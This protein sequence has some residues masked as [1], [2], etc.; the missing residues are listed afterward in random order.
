MIFQPEICRRGFVRP[1]FGGLPNTGILLQDLRF[2]L[3]MLRKSPS[4]AIATVLTLAIAIGANSVALVT[5]DALILRPLNVPHAGNLYEA[6]RVNQENESYPGYLDLRER[7]R[8]F[9][10]LSAVMFAQEEL[11]TGDGASPEWGQWELFRRPGHSAIPWPL[12]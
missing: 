7:N 2:G 6:G 4:F 3:R 5:F 10:S 8:G 11:D 9:E 12:L 1:G